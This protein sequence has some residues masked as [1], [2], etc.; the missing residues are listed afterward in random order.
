MIVDARQLTNNGQMVRMIP[1]LYGG[2]YKF[3]GDDLEQ[4]PVTADHLL[5]SSFKFSDDL[6]I[7]GIL[8]FCFFKYNHTNKTYPSLNIWI[9]GGK[10]TRSYGVSARTGRIVY[11]CSLHGCKNTTELDVVDT[12]RHGPPREFKLEEDREH[13]PLLDDIVVIRRE[14][15]TVRAVEPRTGGERWNFSVGHHELEI[16]KPHDCHNRPQSPLDHTLSSLQLKVIVP[17]GIVCAVDKD[18]PTVVLWQYKVLCTVG[19]QYVLFVDTNFN[20]NIV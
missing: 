5:S 13:D 1:S 10:E 3:D 19:I 12:E 6:V 16:L 4:I 2:L 20:F 9:I 17:D 18:D 8:F 7:S 15:Q 14:T 11:E